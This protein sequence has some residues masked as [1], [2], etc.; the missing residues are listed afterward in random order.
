MRKD[1][2]SKRVGAVVVGVDGSDSANAA[3]HWALAEARLRMAPLRI[4]HTWR[5]SYVGGSDGFTNTLGVDIGDLYR[6]AEELLEKVIGEVVGEVNDVEIERKVVQGSAAEVLIG[7]V[8]AGDLLVV[9]SRGHGGFAGLLLGSVS[10]QCV[11]HAP[12]TVVV[13][14]PPKGTA[15]ARELPRAAPTQTRGTA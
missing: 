4:V 9:G 6:A 3:L 5:S 11:H 8:A 15:R 12:C 2:K 7:A 13:V 10:Q 1:G 14:H